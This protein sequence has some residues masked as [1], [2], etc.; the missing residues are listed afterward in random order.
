MVRENEHRRMDTGT[1]ELMAMARE[2]RAEALGELCELYRNYLRML[3]RRGLGAK[4]RERVEVSDVVQDAMLEVVRQFPQFHGQTEA[5][6]V[7]WM[8][9]L[10]GQKLADLGRF[11]GRSKRAA[12]GNVLSLDAGRD[13]ADRDD[14]RDLPGGRLL[15]A[16]ALEQDSPCEVA[17]RREQCN[18]LADALAGLPEPE[19]EVLWLYH[20]EGLSFEAIGERMGLSRKSIRGIWARGLKALRRALDGRPGTSPRPTSGLAARWRLAGWD[21]PEV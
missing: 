18:R 12:A 1:I 21:R 15:D 20:S 16:L 5:S 10:L 13:L 9:L 11:H 3:A 14:G 8:R 6:L 19:A 4:L 2:G 17:S 7:G